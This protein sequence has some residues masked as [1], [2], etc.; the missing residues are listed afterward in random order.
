M[1]KY[2]LRLRKLL[3]E[4]KT[5]LLTRRVAD[6]TRLM[7]IYTTVVSSSHWCLVLPSTIAYL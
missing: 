5:E 2:V 1:M 6:E 4:L 7:S 3:L